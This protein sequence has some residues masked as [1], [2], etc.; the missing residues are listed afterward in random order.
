MQ[1]I[2]IF[3]LL[4]ICSLTEICAS[5]PPTDGINKL[6]LS[7]FYLEHGQVEHVASDISNY[8]FRRKN[9]YKWPMT[10]IVFSKE[11]DVLKLDITAIDNEWNKIIEPG[12]VA[13]GYFVINNRLF[14]IS[15]ME[16][17]PIDLSEYF[18]P[19]EDGERTFSHA[20]CKNVIKNPKWVYQ[21]DNS[22]VFPK[23]LQ[24]ANVEQLGR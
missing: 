9:G 18:V 13:Y 7:R 2:L 24:S 20:E 19:A 3:T 21:C 11:N 12:E 15:T 4:L 23:Q 14:V 1:K 10:K 22:S 16:G 8:I 17:S 5:T 6:V